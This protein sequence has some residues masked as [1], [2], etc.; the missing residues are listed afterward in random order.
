MKAG[1]PGFESLGMLAGTLTSA[2]TGINNGGD[3]V[4]SSGDRACLFRN[5]QVIDLNTRIAVKTGWML[6]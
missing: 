5:G 6:T 1:S 3:V 4:G 2:A